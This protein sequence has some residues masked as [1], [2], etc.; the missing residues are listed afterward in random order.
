M[1]RVY[2]L[3]A[4]GLTG[5]EKNGSSVA[6]L[7]RRESR[8]DLDQRNASLGPIR[9]GVVEWHLRQCSIRLYGSRDLTAYHQACALLPVVARRPKHLVHAAWRKL[10]VVSIMRTEEE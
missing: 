7:A 3:H 10:P 4:C 9:N 8:W 5:V 6:R 2:A 1:L